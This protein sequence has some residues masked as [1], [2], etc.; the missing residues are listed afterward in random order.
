[1]NYR[2]GVDL[3]LETALLRAVTQYRPLGL[4][5]HFHM[6]AVACELEDRA[7]DIKTAYNMLSALYDIDGLNALEDW[8]EPEWLTDYDAKASRPE[9]VRRRYVQGS[10]PEEFALPW[11][12]FEY[13]IALRRTEDAQDASDGELSDVGSDISEQ[14]ENDK[15]RRSG[16]TNDR[17]TPRK[18][19][20]PEENQDGDTRTNKRRR[21]TSEVTPEP[22]RPL[23]RRQRQREEG[24]E[25]DEDEPQG[26]NAA[27]ATASPATPTVNTRS[28]RRSTGADSARSNKNTRASA[29]P[30]ARSVRTRRS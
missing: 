25:D 11:R 10:D 17:R 6:V 2:A 21:S 12:S 30:A 5:Q 27:A 1:M 29:S 23:T 20:Q 26:D 22:S 28:T 8:P 16:R 15:P 4:H 14:A 13:L 3:A 9:D 24:H 19:N 18:R 7:I